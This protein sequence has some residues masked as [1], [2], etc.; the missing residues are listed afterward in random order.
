MTNMITQHVKDNEKV[1]KRKDKSL[2]DFSLLCI[3]TNIFL[4]NLMLK[5]IIGYCLYIYWID[6]TI[7]NVVQSNNA[8]HSAGSS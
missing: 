2:G 8:K 7:L 1:L 3:E 6:C 4:I 5:T